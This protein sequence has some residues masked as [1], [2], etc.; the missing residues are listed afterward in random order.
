MDAKQPFDPID[1]LAL[2]REIQAALNVSPSPEFLARVRM[3]VVDDGPARPRL[4]IGALGGLA[5]AVTAIVLALVLAPQEER[6]NTPPDAVDAQP[7]SPAGDL[8]RGPVDTPLGAEAPLLR[9]PGPSVGRSVIQ[10]PVIVPVEQV[11]A[12]RRLAEAINAG[13]AFRDEIDLPEP[14]PSAGDEDSQQILANL[15]RPIE[16]L[17]AVKIEPLEIE[18][19]SQ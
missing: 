6:P 17:T 19:I 18:P 2:D 7:P 15:R 8:A 4:A 11:E 3:R 12:F 1:D 9:A 13:T 16:P 14:D 5:V 10:P